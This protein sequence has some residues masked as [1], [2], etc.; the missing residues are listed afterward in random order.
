MEGCHLLSGFFSWC[1]QGMLGCTALSMLLFKRCK[2]RPRRPFKVW[3]MDA[4][5]QA[6]GGLFVHVWNLV[7]AIWVTSLSTGM[8]QA[9]DECALY[10]INYVLDITIGTVSVWWLLLLLQHVAVI[11]NLPSLQR[12]GDYGKP[13]SCSIYLA[14]LV[15]FLF[16]LMTYKTGATLFVVALADPIEQIGVFLIGPLQ[17]YPVLELVVVLVFCPWIINSVQFWVLDSIIMHQGL[18]AEHYEKI[19]DTHRGGRISV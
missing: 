18:S 14:Q 4:S 16:I 8:E 7:L 9:R 6:I 10:F 19:S 11:L 2:E 1:V 3:C 15:V 13:P 17:N 5:K 12:S